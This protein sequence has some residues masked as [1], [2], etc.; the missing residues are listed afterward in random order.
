MVGSDTYFL[1]PERS[2]RD[3]RRLI[4]QSLAVPVS[5]VKFDKKKRCAD[6]TDDDL[7]DVHMVACRAQSRPDH[8]ILPRQWSELLPMATRLS[9]PLVPL[10]DLRIPYETLRHLLKPLLAVQSVNQPLSGTKDVAVLDS[11]AVALLLAA[12]CEGGDVSFEAFETVYEGLGRREGRF[13]NELV[14]ELFVPLRPYNPQCGIDLKPDLLQ[15]LA[16]IFEVF[17]APQ[18]EELIKS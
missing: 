18:S 13:E 9:E 2:E 1:S 8:T 15:C 14:D 5:Y 3:I 7:A 16:K 11:Q 4:F 6:L 17:L 10:E 12:G